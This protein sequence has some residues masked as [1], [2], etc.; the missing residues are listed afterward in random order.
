MTLKQT[1]LVYAADKVT[2]QLDHGDVP[3]R[4]CLV[5]AACHMMVW[6]WHYVQYALP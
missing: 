2:L 6:T 5:Y 3:F 1:Q 4:Q